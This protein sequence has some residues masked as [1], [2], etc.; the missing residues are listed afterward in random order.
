M[1]R[2]VVLP[3]LVA[4]LLGGVLAG[5]RAT[6]QARDG[7][8]EKAKPTIADILEEQIEMKDFQLP[9]T[10]KEALG[11]FYEK[12]ATRGLELPILVDTE[13]FKDGNADAP[14]IYDTQVKFPPFPRRMSLATALRMAV[15][16]IPTGNATYLIRGEH[17]E[18]TT[19]AFAAPKRQTVQARFVN[20]P[21]EEAL[22]E[23]S[24]QSGIAIVLDPRT[25]ESRKTV[26]ATLPTGTN[27]VAATALLADMSG[28]TVRQVDRILYVTARNN[29][30]PLPLETKVKKRK[31]KQTP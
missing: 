21:L 4:L 26:T 20:R 9:M 13:A 8:R 14:D 11:L 15:S 18:I 7:D 19:E 16:R 3:G 2:S 29:N 1:K 23:L 17:V 28:L 10:L 12:M 6:A 5:E 24:R 22:R 30:A 25:Q 31:K 27:L